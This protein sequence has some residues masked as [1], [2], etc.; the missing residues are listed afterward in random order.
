MVTWFSTDLV[1]SLLP[2]GDFGEVFLGTEDFIVDP[3][4]LFFLDSSF[5]VIS[6]GRKDAGT[7]EDGG[8]GIFELLFSGLS[9]PFCFGVVVVF[10]VVA[11]ATEE[12]DDVVEEDDDFGRDVDVDEAASELSEHVELFRFPEE[13]E[14]EL[15]RSVFVAGV[16][17]SDPIWEHVWA[18]RASGDC[19]ESSWK[20]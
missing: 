17:V 15:S 9:F 6:Y 8:E 7:L 2:S 19:F 13:E 1:V 14:D 18:K 11:M 3:P 5:G 10:V 16:G 20:F 4:P 12:W